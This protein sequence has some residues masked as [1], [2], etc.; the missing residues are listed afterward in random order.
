MPDIPGWPPWSPSSRRSPRAQ[1]GIVLPFIWKENYR[2]HS[3]ACACCFAAVF[4]NTALTA[5]FA[6]HRLC[7]PKRCQLPRRSARDS[8]HRFFFIPVL[9]SIRLVLCKNRFKILLAQEPLAA[10]KAT[11]FSLLPSSGSRICVVHRDFLNWRSCFR[12]PKSLCPQTGQCGALGSTD[13]LPTMRWVIPGRRTGCYQKSTI[14]D[15]KE[16]DHVVTVVEPRFEILGP[17]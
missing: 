9:R 11:L 17:S 3:P 16:K 10:A 14:D 15:G 13:P 4:L 5:H 1:P 8:K 6:L 7:Q 12:F 2:A